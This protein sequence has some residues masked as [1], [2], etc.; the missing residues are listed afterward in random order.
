[1]NSKEA[2]EALSGLQI[3]RAVRTTVRPLV[4]LYGESGTGKTYSALLLAR[5]FVGPT[6]QIILGDTESGRG[7]LYADVIPGSYDTVDLQPPFSPVKLIEFIELVEKHASI[8]IV[9]SGSHYWEGPGGVCDMADQNEQRTG[10]A[11]LHCW[12]EPK[13]QHQLMIGR[14]LRSSIPWIIC[15]RAKHKSRQGKNPKTGKAEIVK[16]EFASPIQSEDF[17]F[18]CTIH[19]ETLSNHHFHRT[20]EAHPELCKCFPADGPIEIKH[21]ELLAQWCKGPL[22]A[23]GAQGGTGPSEEARRKGIKRSLW[24]LT[25]P[26]HQGNKAALEQ[27]LW[28]EMIMQDTETLEDL[29]TVRMAEVLA[30][31]TEK[32]KQ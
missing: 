17:V 30:K 10:K 11:G 14:F 26:K 31:A 20:K 15:L 24:E 27:W 32:L 6:G 4:C 23:P 25:E 2:T 16:D 1:M 7:S 19:G 9:D 22:N 5:G 8:G 18:E 3:K 12:R 29:P 13:T 21:G 28:D